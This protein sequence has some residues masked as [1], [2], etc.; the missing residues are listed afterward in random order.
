MGDTL[1]VVI[2]EEVGFGEVLNAPARADRDSG[3]LSLEVSI[4]GRVRWAKARYMTLLNVLLRIF[5]VDNIQSMTLNLLQLFLVS[6]A[7]ARK[8]Q[9]CEGE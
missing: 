1:L 7:K 8:P 9:V 2:I 6:R 3:Y 4:R 5:L